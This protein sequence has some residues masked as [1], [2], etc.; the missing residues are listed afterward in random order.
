MKW[1]QWCFKDYL[2]RDMSSTGKRYFKSF[3]FLMQRFFCLQIIWGN[4]LYKNWVWMKWNAIITMFGVLYAYYDMCATNASPKHRCNAMEEQ[5]FGFIICPSV[6]LDLMN[7]YFKPLSS[8]LLF[9]LW[10]QF[11]SSVYLINL[12]LS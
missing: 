8:H 10:H 11:N 5:L 3:V 9:K 4:V 1:W 12:N 6:S 7:T 2:C